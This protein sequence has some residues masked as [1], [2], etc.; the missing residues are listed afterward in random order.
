[1]LKRNIAMIAAATAVLVGCEAA[2]TSEPD[3]TEA[4]E[5]RIQELEQK[6]QDSAGAPPALAPAKK[7]AAGTTASSTSSRPAETR[8]PAGTTAGH[9]HPPATS[10]STRPKPEPKVTLGPGTELTLV[11]ET[12]LSSVAS[13]VGDRVTARV[14]RAVGE[15]GRVR[16]P[17]G[18]VLTGKVVESVRAGKVK[19]RAR[20]GVDFDRIKV[21]GRSYALDTSVLRV[22]AGDSRKR[23]AKVVGGGAAAGAVV[24]AV[25]GGKKGAGKGALLGAG[26]GAGVVLATRGDEVEMPA[27]SRWKVRVGSP[28]Q[29]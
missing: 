20:L 25:L 3:K 12:P 29:L 14:E 19:G 9:S 17:G 18:T 16:L 22:E 7:P 2:Q 5:Q 6:L 28:L 23:D 24:G 27:G 1:M 21:R 26:T 11:L 13:Q 8:P 15:D 10:T 4:L